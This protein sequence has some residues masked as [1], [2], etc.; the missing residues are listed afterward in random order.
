MTNLIRQFYDKPDV[1]DF[2]K[3]A[4]G[5]I[6]FL[7]LLIYPPPLWLNDMVIDR[8]NLITVLVLI[9]FFIFL[10]NRNEDG[11]ETAQIAFIFALFAI[12]LVYRWQSAHY[13]GY[14]IGGLLPWS[15]A[16]DYNW[17]AHRLTN[18]SLL[19]SWGARRPLFSGFLAVL[20]RLTGGDFTIT[21]SVLTLLNT[22][23]VFF[24]VRVVK[25]FYGPIAAAFFLIISFAFYRQFPG[26]TTSEQLGF[27][28]ANLALF[29]LL[30]GARARSL[31]RVLFGL[32]LLTLAL[33]ARAGA[34]FILPALILW[35]ALSFRPRMPFW[36]T[37]GLAV[38]V[39]IT[40]FMLNLIL[41]RLIADP[42]S[43]LFSN[44]SYTLY[45]LASGNKGW[46][47][48]I[49]DHP[50]VT[51]REV[52]PLAIQKIRSEPTL[53]LQGMLGT[54]ADYFR[55]LRGAFTFI[56]QGSIRRQVNLMLWGLVVSGLV[57]S[58]S[59]WK[60]GLQGL[61]L[62]SFLG[63]IFSIP[64]LPPIDA[65][66]M[67]VFAATVPFSALWVAAGVSALSAWGRK[68]ISQKDGCDTGNE[69]GSYFQKPAL[70]FSILLVSLAVFAPL[71][72][73][74]FAH[75]PSA[76]D[77][78]SQPACA[79]G[80]ELLNGIK[81]KNISI[82]I[83]QDDAADESYTPFIRISDFQK[84][85]T[86]RTSFYPFLDEELLN[87]KAGDQISFGLKLVHGMP[88]KGLWMVSEF[89][90]MEGEFKI[91]GRVADN[92][93]PQLNNFYYLEGASVRASSLTVSQEHPTLTRL[94]RLLY[95]VTIGIV[96]FLLVMGLIGFANHS[97]VGFL[98]TAGIMILILPGVFVSL[99]VNGKLLSI[100][101]PVE[102]RITLQMRHVLPREGNLHILPLG[103]DW[104]SQA[105]L[106]KSPA[107][108]YENGIPLQWPN[109]LHQAI[110]EKGNGRYSV[111]EGTLFFSSSDNTDPRVNGRVYEIEWPRPI[112]PILQR[113]SYLI[114]ISGVSLI[115]LG[116]YI[117][118]KTVDRQTKNIPGGK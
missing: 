85:I 98:C 76:P 78:L 41:V 47:Q 90:V 109:S 99:Y 15:D 26:W 86:I 104:M 115:F 3:L 95:G 56:Y 84:A 77:S 55:P 27:A 114:G 6:V 10:L 49:R 74:A 63:V 36:R 75:T 117:M 31:W 101:I 24:V 13:D 94:I 57:G 111:W 103:I 62:A 80:E 8:Y 59:K 38:A 42:H 34:F 44:Y 17:Q 19:T 45:G 25:R 43:A 88:G 54:F 14:T 50:E 66:S 46:D 68:L 73:K 89:P 65:D 71:L 96:L 72:L 112:P 82:L 4:V 107:V 39:V 30:I 35:A 93:E 16:A 69:T 40:G 108:V 70:S 22:L 12:P 7:L 110:R 102:Q 67:R 51:E 20:L 100:P 116:K 32:G 105:D 2:G 113:L 5:V 48:V 61:T 52:M 64:L 28:I 37:G 21:V 87:L 11:W 83:I 92:K 18:G 33:N 106:G 9:A 29:F 118:Q 60:D 23:A 1:A 79:P 91:C 81:F 97:W 58:I 53:L